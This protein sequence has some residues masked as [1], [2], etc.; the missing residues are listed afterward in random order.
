[1]FA[2]LPLNYSYLLL[3][4]AASTLGPSFFS[5]YSYYRAVIGA[6]MVK[7]LP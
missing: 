2:Y 4:F 7:V 3:Y 6:E 1:M 5:F